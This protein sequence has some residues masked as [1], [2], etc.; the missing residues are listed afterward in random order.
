MFKPM[1]SFQFKSRYKRIQRATLKATHG[2][3][4]YNL[5][6]IIMAYKSIANQFGLANF[7][8]VLKRI[9]ACANLIDNNIPL[10]L[11]LKY[12]ADQLQSF[13]TTKKNSVTNYIKGRR[14]LK[15]RYKLLYK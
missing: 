12:T 15:K 10:A 7:I 8:K 3:E 9:I 1:H 14:T 5:L 2:H 6:R 11:K 13:T 4:S